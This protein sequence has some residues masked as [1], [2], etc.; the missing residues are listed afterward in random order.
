MRELKYLAAFNVD[1]VNK[2][3]IVCSCMYVINWMINA[4]IESS[5]LFI[6]RIDF[7]YLCNFTFDFCYT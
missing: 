2:V 7:H 5:Y 3:V 1:W 6:E 4:Q